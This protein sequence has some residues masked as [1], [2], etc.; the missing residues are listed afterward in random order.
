MANKHMKKMLS[1]TNH[2]GNVHQNQDDMKTED[3]KSWQG[4]GK[5]ESLCIAGW[6]VNSTVAMENSVKFLKNFNT[7]LSYDLVIPLL[8]YPKELKAGTLIPRFIAA[9]FRIANCG[10]NRRDEWINKMQV[11]TKP[12]DIIQP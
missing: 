1:I 3:N 8:V 10:S 4:C 7:E 12:G 6:N 2:Q 5:M 9:V 11:Y